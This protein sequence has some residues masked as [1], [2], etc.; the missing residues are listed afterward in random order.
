MTRRRGSGILP[1][2]TQPA[3][4]FVKFRGWLLWARRVHRREY[5]AAALATVGLDGAPDVRMVLLKGFDTRGFVFYTNLESRKAQQLAA[6]PRAS[7]CFFWNP[8]FFFKL[9]KY[10]QVRVDG[11][12]SLVS[13]AEADAYFATRARGSQIGAWASPQ[14]RVIATR[15]E[16]EAQFREFERKFA[17]Q[18]VPRPPYWSGYRLAAERIEF[19]TSRLNRLHDRELYTRQG[20]GWKVEVLAP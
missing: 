5:T 11:R 16:L 7:L 18:K 19:W 8:V 12:C 9:P 3:D 1:G 17:G 20:D 15:A 6:D 2:M 10:H 4:P 14:S 13:E